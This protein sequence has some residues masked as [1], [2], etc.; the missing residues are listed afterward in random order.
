MG[1]PKLVLTS[2]SRNH[3]QS[4]VAVRLGEAKALVVSVSRLS[5]IQV[6]PRILADVTGTLKIPKP[7]RPTA[8]RVEKNLS[9]FVDGILDV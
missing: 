1:S 3:I 2:L 9:F 7:V 8:L 4:L 6:R 5:S